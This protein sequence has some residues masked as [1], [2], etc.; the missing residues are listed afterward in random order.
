MMHDGDNGELPR[1][2]RVLLFEPGAFDPDPEDVLDAFSAEAEDGGRPQGTTTTR[3]EE[4]AA[5][6]PSSE[7]GEGLS[8]SSVP[9]C[10]SGTPDAAA[11]A[12]P[13]T[14]DAAALAASGPDA[15]PDPPG[16]AESCPDGTGP[17]VSFL[18]SPCSHVTR[19]SARSAG[20]GTVSPA[21]DRLAVPA[22]PEAPASVA[23]ASPEGEGAGGDGKARRAHLIHLGAAAPDS[24]YGSFKKWLSKAFREL[25]TEAEQ[26]RLPGRVETERFCGACARMTELDGRGSERFPVFLADVARF[27]AA[28]MAGDAPAAR[29]AL[30][31]LD[32][33]RLTCHALYK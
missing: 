14:P 12:A 8:R 9:A 7:A 20:C 2:R 29:A 22:T 27:A 15:A 13:G 1:G 19:G 10:A 24:D 30:D 28:V 3:P 17:R 11:L 5:D 26:G 4:G 6:D 33:H 21:H 31:A 16:H 32:S 23:P 18:V 25:R